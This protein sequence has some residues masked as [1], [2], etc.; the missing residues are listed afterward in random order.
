M[1]DES[2]IDQAS[3]E[4]KPRLEVFREYDRHPVVPLQA[5]WLAAI[6]IVGVVRRPCLETT[7]GPV[8]ICDERAC[9]IV[10]RLPFVPYGIA[11][12][13]A[14][15]AA[16]FPPEDPNGFVAAAMLLLSAW[17]RDYK[18][19]DATARDIVIW[20][21]HAERASDARGDTMVMRVDAISA[22]RGG[23]DG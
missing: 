21:E 9:A 8:S 17:R 19:S 15:C 14:Q 7:D 6:E 11:E 5:L 1:T 4:R 2:R 3:G 12:E 20:L 22:L 13:I 23:V 18:W 16:M 10:R